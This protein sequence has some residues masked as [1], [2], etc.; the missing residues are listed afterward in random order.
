MA[1]ITK[2]DE[3]IV[4]VSWNQYQKFFKYLD[5]YYWNIFK[6]AFIGVSDT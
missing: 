4:P 2:Y 6:I 3:D 1:L 5:I